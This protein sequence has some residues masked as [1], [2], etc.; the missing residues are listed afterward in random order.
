MP[1]VRQQQKSG[2]AILPIQ[3]KT[4]YSGKMATPIWS[5]VIA[6]IAISLIRFVSRF[7]FSRCSCMVKK[8]LIWYRILQQAH[9]DCAF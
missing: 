2:K 3:R 1:T 6:T 5:I 7:V 4:G 8:L 9:T